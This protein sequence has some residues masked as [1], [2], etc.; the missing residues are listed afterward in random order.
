[1][2]GVLIKGD[3]YKNVSIHLAWTIQ[4]VIKM[5]NILVLG[6]PCTRTCSLNKF[7]VIQIMIVSRCRHLLEVFEDRDHT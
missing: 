3:V 2:R 6:F 1:M 7:F 5:G 4:I